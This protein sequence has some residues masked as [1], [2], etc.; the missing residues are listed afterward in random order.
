MYRVAEWS[1][2]WN[3]LVHRFAVMYYKRILLRFVSQNQINKPSVHS[4]ALC[5]KLPSIV[6]LKPL[7]NYF[8]KYEIQFPVIDIF[9]KNIFLNFHLQEALKTPK[10]VLCILAWW[11]ET[12]TNAMTWF[13]DPSFVW[14]CSYNFKRFHSEF[15]IFF[16]NH[17]LKQFH[18]DYQF[19]H[20]SMAKDPS[21]Y[22]AFVVQMLFQTKS[23]PSFN[24]WKF[25]GNSNGKFWE[26]KTLKV[27]AWNLELFD[28]R[29]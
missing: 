25:E 29:L 28:L 19:C 26:L 27:L 21:W 20:F 3:I 2:I 11:I 24:L 9:P 8:R 5:S 18:C 16:L 14:K 15:Y 6:K 22:M 17:P 7:R 10:N 12:E 13:Y 4:Y 23:N 1:T